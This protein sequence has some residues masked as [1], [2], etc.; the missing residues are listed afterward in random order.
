[1]IDFCNDAGDGDFSEGVRLT[2]HRAMTS[3][4]HVE[5]CQLDSDAK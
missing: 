1:M 2:L 4:E 5:D 3:I